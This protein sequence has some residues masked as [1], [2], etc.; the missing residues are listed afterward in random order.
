MAD[1]S[2]DMIKPEPVTPKVDTSKWPLLLKNYSNLLVRS[3]HFTPIPQ[4]C[5]PL[6]RDLQSYI[7]CVYNYM[8]A[9]AKAYTELDFCFC[10]FH[11]RSVYALDFLLPVYNVIG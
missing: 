6:K 7:K 10:Y 5:S 8:H 1:T 2:K 4:G 3:S 9:I 11:F